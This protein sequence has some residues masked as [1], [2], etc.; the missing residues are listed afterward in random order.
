MPAWKSKRVQEKQSKKASKR[1]W[2]KTPSP[3]P[4]NS[5]TRKKHV[6]I[7]RRKISRK[8]NS[9]EFRKYLKS[10]Q[11]KNAW[12]PKTRKK[13][14]S[15][16]RKK[17]AK[18]GKRWATDW[19]YNAM[20]EVSPGELERYK[21]RNK[22]SVSPIGLP[23]WPPKAPSPSEL[24]PP[25]F[26]PSVSPTPS[27]NLTEDD[28]KVLSSAVKDVFKSKT[29][30]PTPKLLRPM[31]IKSVRTKRDT[32]L[33]TPAQ[34]MLLAPSDIASG[35]KK[36]KKRKTQK[37]RK[38]KKQKGGKIPS[39]P[40]PGMNRRTRKTLPPGLSHKKNRTRKIHNLASRLRSKS[41][42]KMGKS[43]NKIQ[44]RRTKSEP[45]IGKNKRL[46]DLSV[47]AKI[48]AAL[49]SKRAR[50]NGFSNNARDLLQG[51]Q[52]T[53]KPEEVGLDEDTLKL[54]KS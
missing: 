32:N 49:A 11:T 22:K 43:N 20:L 25:K 18:K 37:K 16:K 19:D 6:S 33:L 45:T 1:R 40:P 41:L 21:E 17:T 23:N 31:D 51:I 42:P 26:K 10:K 15:P 34:I 36:T 5:R 29:P 38:R 27:I 30:S 24:P 44:I 28:Y 8:G 50:N 48:A 52:S 14:P 47:K 9:K 39:S 13:S 54:I 3:S 46:V 35:P 53:E 4:R 7:D 2:K 12:K